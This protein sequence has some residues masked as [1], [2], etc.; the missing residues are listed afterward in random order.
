MGRDVYAGNTGHGIFLFNCGS[1]IPEPFFTDTGPRLNTDEPAMRYSEPYKS[2]YD[3][4][5]VTIVD[6]EGFHKTSR[7]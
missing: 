3:S 4:L 6:Y 1:V 2:S 7:A 5:I